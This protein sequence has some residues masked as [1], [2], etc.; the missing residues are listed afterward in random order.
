MTNKNNLEIQERL[1]E[2]EDR[3]IE[4]LLEIANIND[5]YNEMILQLNSE[6]AQL[7]KEYYQ[8]QLEFIRKKQKG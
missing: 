6:Y 8:L 4:I 3:K 2:I 5:N 7:H 1:R